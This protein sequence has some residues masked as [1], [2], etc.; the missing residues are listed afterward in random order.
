MRSISVG[1]A[2]LHRTVIRAACGVALLAAVAGVPLAHAQNNKVA[3]EALFEEGR[4]LMAAGKPTEACPKFADSQKL[5][6]SVSTLL[7]LAN[8]YEKAGRSA[9]AWA[10]YK[11]AASAASVA[12]RGDLL[13]T[14]QKRATALE[15]TLA[16]IQV[17]ATTPVDG[18]EIK[19]D[20]VPL[21]QA[22]WGIAIPVD[23]GSHNIEA[24][25]PKKLSWATQIDVKEPG[26]TVTV[27]IPTLKDAPVEP[28]PPPTATTTAPPP[29]PPTAT[30]SAP[31]PPPLPP[32]EDGSGRRTVG[33]IV[34]GAGVVGL[35]L[36]T[37][38][39]LS[40][41]SKYDESLK[42]CGTDK[43]LCTQPGVDQ[44]DS[45][46]TAGN[47]ASVGFGVGA[48]LVATGAV[49]W[50]TAPSGNGKTGDKGSIQV[51]PTLGGAMVRGQF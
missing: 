18:L 27:T 48:V 46:R 11:E 26:K 29:P 25:A 1:S 20:G 13:V 42:A 10:T 51:A 14:A 41:K 32:A 47:I 24:T 9:S 6:P 35:A 5:D 37:V 21:S 28:P 22:E 33:L 49:L 19:R 43:N 2:R 17:T 50:F 31:P 3:A 34:G 12:H 7:N 30:T 39:A 40:A 15:P 4:K 16:R 23:P 36:G 38:F 8:C 44:R 45:A